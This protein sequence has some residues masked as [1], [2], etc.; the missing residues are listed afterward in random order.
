MRLT[1]HGLLLYLAAALHKFLINGTPYRTQ[2]VLAPG[3]LHPI[4][5]GSYCT[6]SCPCTWGLT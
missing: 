3:H 2:L 5:Y 4:V 1:A 6:K